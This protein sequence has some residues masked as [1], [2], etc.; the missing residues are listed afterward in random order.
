MEDNKNKFG[1]FG[2]VFTPCT[3]TILGVIM[4]LRFGQVIGNSGIFHGLLIILMA[5]VITTLTTLSL[6]AITTNT[7]VKGGGA[8]YIISRSLGVEF[9]GAI[10]LVFFLSQAISVAL[11]IIGFTE[12]LSS[13]YAQVADNFLLTASVVNFIVF[14]CIYIGAAWAIKIQFFILAILGA[15]ILSFVIGGVQN[16]DQNL[17]HSNFWPQYSQNHNIWTMFALFF[18]AA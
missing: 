6:A 7:R 10:G 18:P 3:L 15:S 5:K 11:Y 14:V 17:M 4:F 16:F 9:G 13:R 1:T 12:A 8:Y 2:G